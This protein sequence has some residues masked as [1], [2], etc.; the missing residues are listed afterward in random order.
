MREIKI[1]E[2]GP[3]RHLLDVAERLFAAKGFESVSV[4]DIT[5]EAV[6]N[7]AAVNY[8]FGGRDTL[9]ALVIGRHLRPVNEER[10][11]RVEVLEKKSPGKGVVPVEEIIE[12][13][14]R[15][16]VGAV[17]KSG[18][19][20]PAACELLG[21]ILAWRGPGFPGELE[22]QTQ[23]VIARFMR[24]LGK[25]LPTVSA[26]ELVWR[27]HFVTGGM[28]QMLMGRAGVEVSGATAIDA[29]LGRFIRFA[30]AGLREGVEAESAVKKGPQ[31]TFDF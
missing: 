12:A 27:M 7:V 10:A 19:P 2:S 21:R 26:E 5:R 23:T 13:L 25:A 29:T 16:L 22:M 8:H 11:A 6:V 30:T 15:P 24:I 14:A 28:I 3:K 18:L 17:R 9:V 31:A 20:E 4:R 1:P